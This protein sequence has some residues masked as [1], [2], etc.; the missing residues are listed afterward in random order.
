MLFLIQG[1][2]C[3]MTWPRKWCCKHFSHIK[4][5]I[6]HHYQRSRSKGD[7]TLCLLPA[8]NEL[9]LCYSVVN[10]SLK[11]ASTIKQSVLVA[12]CWPSLA[13]KSTDLSSIAFGT[14]EPLPEIVALI[15]RLLQPH[16]AKHSTFLNS[17]SFAHNYKLQKWLLM[18]EV[19]AK[20]SLSLCHYTVLSTD[21]FAIS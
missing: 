4:D 10:I 18:V 11:R 9:D 2:G 5:S 1:D 7:T 16:K 19:N 21:R 3:F 20:Q 17:F 6:F 13:E 12:T 15:L 14:G 8:V